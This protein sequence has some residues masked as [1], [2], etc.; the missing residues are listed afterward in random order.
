MALRR[1]PARHRRRS[2]SPLGRGAVGGAR[3]QR[4]ARPRARR[5]PHPVRRRSRDG[6]PGRRCRWR[7]ASALLLVLG[8]VAV[9]AARAGPA[10]GGPGPDRPPTSAAH[11]GRARAVRRTW[12]RSRSTARPAPPLARAAAASRRRRRGT[13]GRAG[14]G[15]GLPGGRVAADG[16]GGD[17]QRPGPRRPAGPGRGAGGARDRGA[18]R[19][20]GAGPT[21]M[22]SGGGYSGPLVYRDGKP[23]CP[24]V[25][26]AFDLMDAAAHGSG[27]DL[28][29]DQRLPQRRRA[30]GA[31]RAP[32]RPE[33]GRAAGAQ[34]A[35]GRHRARPQHGQ[36]AA[37][38]TPGWPPTRALRVHPA[39][40]LGALALG[41]PARVRRWGGRRRWRP[42]RRSARCPTGCRRTCGPWSPRRRRP[43]AWPR[44]C[45]RRCCDRSRAST[46]GR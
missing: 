3:R 35:P 33:V 6:A 12:G 31:L 13:G 26:A 36:P 17:G 46:P 41:L 4:P 37:R 43:T 29:G 11:L 22:A 18:R 23:M 45:S 38:R 40:L 14:G 19:R 28:V 34:P 16:G 32:S 30:G 20:R 1:R 2:W 9:F 39:V 24:A 5:G 8:A 25:G 42:G 7:S 21:G 10:G 15:A 27:V 44:S